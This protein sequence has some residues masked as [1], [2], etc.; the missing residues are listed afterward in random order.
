VLYLILEGLFSLLEYFT[1]GER[2]DWQA[3]E[4]VLSSDGPR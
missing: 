1:G 3:T 4:A 2:T